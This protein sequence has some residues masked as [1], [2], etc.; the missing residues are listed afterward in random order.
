MRTYFL[1]LIGGQWFGLDTECVT[2]VGI[3]NESKEKGKK[4]LLLPDG[5]L[6][7]V[8]DLQPLLGGE[9]ASCAC[10]SHYLII[11]HQGRFIALVMAGKGRFAMVDDTSP[12]VLPPA[13]IGIAR[14]LIPGAV[15][16]C[17]D[18]I[19]QLNLEALEKVNDW[20]ASR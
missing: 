12:R 5:N 14:E 7:T 9:P 2:N 4:E 19:L 16:N 1:A 11:T 10:P 3:Y 13:F 20:M 8:C 18:V 17:T 15:I 6:A